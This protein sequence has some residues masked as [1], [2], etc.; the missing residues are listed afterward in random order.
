M[1]RKETIDN[2]VLRISKYIEVINNP[3][4]LANYKFPEDESIIAITH[5]IEKQAALLRELI[6][7][8]AAGEKDLKI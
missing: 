4:E 6:L 8:K 2:C 7:R 1:T 5:L 3:K